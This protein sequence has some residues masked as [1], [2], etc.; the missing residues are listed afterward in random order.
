MTLLFKNRLGDLLAEVDSDTIFADSI[1][2]T[3]HACPICKRE[4]VVGRDDGCWYLLG[5]DG[6]SAC[7]GTYA[8]PDTGE[9]AD[10]IKKS[11]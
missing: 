10:M 6:C 3:L 5:T 8:M 9:L 4:P 7:T 2:A 1:S 11:E